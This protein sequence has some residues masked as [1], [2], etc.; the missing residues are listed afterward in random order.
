MDTGEE[1]S[2]GFV[3]T[4]CDGAELL[5]FGEEILDQVA[6]F[7]DVP[8][9]IPADSAVCLGWDHDR[10]V[11]VREQGDDPLIGVERFVGE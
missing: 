7:V 10:L 6:R 3:V 9:I 11:L 8:V 5:E 4:G 2:G 1:V